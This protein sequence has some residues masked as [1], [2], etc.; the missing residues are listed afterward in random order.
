MAE[1]R[2]GYNKSEIP[3]EKVHAQSALELYLDGYN[4]GKLQYQRK[5]RRRRSEKVGP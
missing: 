2:A 5:E 1:G 4:I 3:F